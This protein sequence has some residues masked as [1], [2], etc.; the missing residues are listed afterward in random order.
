MSTGA[1][2]HHKSFRLYRCILHPTLFNNCNESIVSSKGECSRGLHCSSLRSKV[3]SSI[4]YTFYSDLC[5]RAH[6]HTH[7]C[8]S[9]SVIVLTLTKPAAHC[10]MVHAPLAAVRV[11]FIAAHIR[12]V[13]TAP[14]A[15]V[16]VWT[17]VGL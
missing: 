1:F 12:H 14:H 10:G 15:G 7:T 5:V 6:T 11:L 16:D 13:A 2:L 4:N 9:G 17:R 8:G 3:Q